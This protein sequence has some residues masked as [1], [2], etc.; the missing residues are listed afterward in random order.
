MT[1]SDLRSNPIKDYAPDMDE[2]TFLGDLSFLGMDDTQ[3]STNCGGQTETLHG[4]TVCSPGS[5]VGIE[6]NAGEDHSKKSSPV[7]SVILDACLVVVLVLVFVAAWHKRR[8]RK[9]KLNEMVQKGIAD[10]RSRESGIWD[11]EVLLKHRLD[12]DLVKKLKLIST[13]M[14]GEVWLALYKNEQVA[15]K[16]LKEKDA[17]REQIHDFIDEIKLISTFTHPKVVRFIGVVWTKESD[18][19]VLTE[20]MPNGD[21]R[22]YLDGS[23]KNLDGWDDRM[24]QI[25]LDITE[26]LVYLHSLEP[27]LIHRDLKSRNVL[28]DD[29]LNARLSDFG[30]SRYKMD[31]ETM[32]ACVGTIRWVA[33]EVLAG[34]PYD[35]SVDVFSLGII[36]SEIDTHKIPYFDA[37]GEDN[38]VLSDT[39]IAS[40]VLSG[41]LTASFSSSCPSE[42]LSLANRCT[43]HEPH[44]RP[45]A[46]QVAYELRQLL[47]QSRSQSSASSSTFPSSRQRSDDDQGRDSIPPG[48]IAV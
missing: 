47:R 19:A 22:K 26:A 37:R 30:V 11:D 18:I 28:L 39:A 5:K 32:T 17:T 14:F 24:I 40:L 36:L 31:D 27:Q 10:F 16:H 44:L 21:L 2:F 6:N 8:L 33:P 25:A 23:E 46:M 15:I 9:Q 48:V 20:Y 13:G 7:L 1:P 3:F 38:E 42:I 4:Y 45:N 34:D 29:E 35:E 41:S 43:S 12:L